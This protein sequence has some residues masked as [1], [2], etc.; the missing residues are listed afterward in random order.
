MEHPEKVNAIM[1]EWLEEHFPPTRGEDGAQTPES[2]SEEPER[3]PVHEE[4]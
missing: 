2:V 1:R 3:A 4:L